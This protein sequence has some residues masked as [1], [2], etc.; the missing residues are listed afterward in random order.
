MDMVAAVRAMYEQLLCRSAK[1]AVSNSKPR[2]PSATPAWE[3]D[4]TRVGRLVARRGAMFANLPRTNLLGDLIVAGAN[5]AL[6]HAHDVITVVR[7]S[8]RADV[9]GRRHLVSRRAGRAS[10]LRDPGASPSSFGR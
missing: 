8:S 6:L 7:D 1:V 3:P 10:R 5:G 4:P 2:V 9:A